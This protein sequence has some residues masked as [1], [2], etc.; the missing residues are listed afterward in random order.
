[1][2]HSR[3]QLS[4]PAPPEFLAQVR[5]L[6]P[7]I[8]QLLYNRGLTD[9]GQ[10]ESF[11]SAD[12]RLAGD[13]FLLPDIQP[14]ISRV[15]RALLCDEEITVYGDFDTDG[16]TATAVLTQGLSQLGGKVTPY[17]PHRVHEGHG[18]RTNAL[19][20]LYDK[21]ISLVITA[22]CGVTGTEEVW[23]A[24]RRGLD[25]VITD[26]HMPL[27]DI[28]PAI[29]I[30]NPKMPGS[31]YPFTELAG[32]GVAFKFFQAILQGLGRES[33]IEP[34]LDLVALGTIADV[35]P[36]IS[37]NRYLV[38]AGLER[39]NHEP[40]LGIR[41]MITQTG[42]TPGKL[43]AEAVSWV[44]APRLNTT[45]RLDHALP[46]YQL[47]VTDSV[48]EA[49]ELSLW[50]EQS[51][52]Q[53]QQ[54][55]TDVV[56]RVRERILA[57][58][59]QPVLIAADEEYPAG[60]IG[61]AAGRLSEEFYRPVVVIKTGK[62][63]CHGSC[64]SIPE[65]NMIRALN[66]CHH[67]FHRFGGH[68]QAAG[69]SIPTKHLPELRE[70]LREQATTELAGIDLRPHLNI[71]LEAR[72]SDLGG[73]MFPTMRTLAPFGC[74]NPHPTFLSR[75]VDV[76]GC[77]TMGSS[78]AHLRMRLR[79]DGIIWDAVAFGASN[80]VKEITSPLDI[81]YNLELDQWRGEERLRLNLCDFSPSNG[82]H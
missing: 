68:P 57:E 71:D 40:R 36:L 58:G 16:I 10:L 43:D 79:Q 66:R 17:I 33:G 4:A 20:R 39:L 65:F 72:L 75:E 80:Y 7:L 30:V 49:R 64:R 26:H 78:G 19:D 31:K 51:N 60:I 34:L 21:G 14:A 77:Q 18:L 22:D 73:N 82:H 29:A 23:K 42:L 41:E 63:V 11:L 5:E 6:S 53:R 27:D 70:S 24:Q 47:L 48:R 50:L 8:G 44:I 76:L 37:E 3:W 15:F 13:P 62:Q 35:M 38:K 54:M 1:M 52:S 32:V 25:I 69:F 12:R 56:G 2:N 45:G 81:V 46:S 9:P 67:L 55:T 74:G 59:I 28:P 61:L